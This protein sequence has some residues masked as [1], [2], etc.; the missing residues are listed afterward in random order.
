MAIDPHQWIRHRRREPLPDEECN[1]PADARPPLIMATARTRMAKR[2]MTPS[3]RCALRHLEV[4][5]REWEAL[6]AVEISMDA[7]VGS[8]QDEFDGM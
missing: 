2:L 1:S 3:S 6:C 5:A 4:R 8:Y 7:E